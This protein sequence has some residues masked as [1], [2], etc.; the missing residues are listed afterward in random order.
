MRIFSWSTLST[1]QRSS[2]P[3]LT[4][5]GVAD[6]LGPA[7]VRDVQ[8]AVDAFLDLDEGAVVGEVADGALD[9]GA[10]RVLL[11]DGGPG[12]DLG[13][14]HAERDFLLVL[15][16]VEDDDLDLSP[17]LRISDGWLM[18][19]VQLISEMWTRPS[20]PASSFTKAP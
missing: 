2:S 18:R 6:L 5:S 20:M 4:T 15:V 7:H 14:L 3:F 13:L 8:Q 1:T 19:R 12:V 16:D 11:G 10:R 9:D 17:T